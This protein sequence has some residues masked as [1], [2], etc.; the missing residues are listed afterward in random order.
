MGSLHVDVATV[1]DK[2]KQYVVPVCVPELV[3]VSS[4]QRGAQL[5]KTPPVVSAE[6]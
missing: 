2:S 4:W 3:G 6:T 1:L 5:R